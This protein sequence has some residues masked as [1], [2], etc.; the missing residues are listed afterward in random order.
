VPPEQ[1]RDPVG[2]LLDSGKFGRDPERTPMQ[3]SAGPGAGFTTDEPWLPLA[4]D[5][6][7][8]NVEAQQQDEDSMLAFYRELLE[9]RRKEPALQI[10]VYVPAGQKKNLFAFLRE[11]DDQCFLIAVNLG[12][13]RARLAIPRHLDVTGEVVLGTDPKRVGDKISQYVNL[14]PDEGLIARIKP[15]D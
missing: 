10:G 3:W 8:A 1:E 14:G 2:K 13:T 15:C 5:C 4:E 6:A 11:L 9:L 7:R 12:G